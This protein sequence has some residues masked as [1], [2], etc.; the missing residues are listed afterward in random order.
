MA[1]D[2]ESEEGF[3]RFVH[4]LSTAIKDLASD[5]HLAELIRAA[6][7]SNGADVSSWGTLCRD[8]IDSRAARPGC[9]A[10]GCFAL[11]AAPVWLAAYRGDEAIVKELL[12]HSA[13][14][15]ARCRA[16]GGGRSC[17]VGGYSA[18]HLAVSRGSLDC[19]QRLLE[20]GASPHE[21]M[22]FGVD[23]DDEPDWDDDLDTFTVGLAGQCVLEMAAARHSVDGDVCAALLAHG[24]DASPLIKLAGSSS[25][26]EAIVGDDGL[27][28]ECAICPS[29]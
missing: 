13:D 2:L 10:A 11:T 17:S 5:V 23:D 8:R 21:E 26:L 19:V 25:G 20:L 3:G 6:R 15:D 29:P 9:F 27:A 22:C 18:L 24:A 14:P 12:R 16:C 4:G 28:L 1:D 7:R